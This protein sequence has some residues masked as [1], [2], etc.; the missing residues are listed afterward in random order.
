MTLKR[1]SGRLACKSCLP[2]FAL[3]KSGYT[4]RERANPVVFLHPLIWICI[5]TLMRHWP[6]LPARIAGVLMIGICVHAIGAL[7]PEALPGVFFAAGLLRSTC[8]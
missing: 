2:N 5:L 3:I 6:S 8:S 1:H 7:M 4:I